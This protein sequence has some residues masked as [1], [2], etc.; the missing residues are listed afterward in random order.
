MRLIITTAA[1]LLCSACQQPAPTPAAKTD[2]AAERA[3]VDKLEAGQIA[4]INA[5]D[6]KS[7]ASVYSSDA[8]FVGQNGEPHGAAE[9]ATMFDAISKDPNIRVD[10]HPGKKTFSEDGTMAYATASYTET[11]TD[12]T[13]KKVVTEKGTNLSVWRKQAD[14]SWRLVADSNPGVTTG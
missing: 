7:A 11:Y 3:A 4:A 14:G 2:L 5:K 10:F 1:L 13:T 6:G 8:V 9:I 12:P